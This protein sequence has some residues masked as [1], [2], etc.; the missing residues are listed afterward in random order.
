ME[1]TSAWCILH[2]YEALGLRQ[3]DQSCH[4]EVWL[5]L[6]FDEHHDEYEP[7]ERHEQ[8]V[9]VTERSA[10]YQPAKKDA[11]QVRTNATVRFR[12]QRQATI[13]YRHDRHARSTAPGHT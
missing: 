6:V 7:R 8:R 2:L 5:H 4:H 10:L 12:P 1:S 9:V 3:K 13:R 11:G